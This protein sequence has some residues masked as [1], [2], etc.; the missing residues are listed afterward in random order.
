MRVR[1]LSLLLVLTVLLLSALNGCAK[2]FDPRSLANRPQV[3]GLIASPPEPSFA[4]EAEVRVIVS[5]PEDVV[6]Y[7]WSLC[8]FTLGAMA[9]YACAAPEM[10]IPGD[11]L[12]DAARVKGSA[13]EAGLA[14]LASSFSEIEKGL[15]QTKPDDCVGPML[16]DYDACVAAAGADSDLVGCDAIATEAYV[17][18]LRAAGMEMQI[19]VV[20]HW[21]D[22][23][24][25]EAVKRV[26]F[27]DLDPE[28]PAN[29]NPQLLGLE[30][31]GQPVVDGQEI[32]VAPGESFELLPI[33]RDEASDFDSVETYLDPE[34]VSTEESVFFTWFASAGHIK[35]QRT[36][37]EF[38]DNDWRAPKAD[39]EEAQEPITLWVF[40]RDDR[41][42]ADVLTLHL[43]VDAS[44]TEGT[45][46]AE[47]T[48]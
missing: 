10:P 16:D 47:V 37:P 14:M 12:D 36:T 35:Y 15:R 2:D 48:P 28:R 13:L 7:E 38:A 29:E 17:A 32:R 42:G 41:L 21:E 5:F 40:V 34:G 18:C 43:L 19:R 25:V 8:P 3:L 22:G 27:R 11:A 45:V 4:E 1:Y 30:I 9:G 26:R 44:L 33:F 46:T 24:A 23:T 31:D 20:A 39:D 6:A